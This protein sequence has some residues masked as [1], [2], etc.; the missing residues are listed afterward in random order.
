LGTVNDII[1]VV[2]LN[3]KELKLNLEKNNINEIL[4][5]C[6]DIIAHKLQEK[7]LYLKIYKNKHV[8][9][10]FMI[11]HNKFKQLLLCLLS[12]SVQNTNIGG[13]IIKLKL[14]DGIKIK[15]KH[16]KNNMDETK[17][18]IEIHRSSYLFANK[19][20]NEVLQIDNS[21]ND[22][23]SQNIQKFNSLDD[24]T[25][26]N[27]LFSIKDSGS[28]MIDKIQQYVEHILDITN[29]NTN[30]KTYSYE[31]VGLGLIISKFLCN[32]M[33]GRIWFQTMPN[34]GTIFYFNIVCPKIS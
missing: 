3:K 6:R 4:L 14:L 15:K 16:D 20:K 17:T 22:T 27:L 31:Y 7:K 25:K 23:I 29:S 26:Y 18:Y 28:G 11:D 33:G 5:D 34:I 10:E 32:L 30:Q 1:D 9:N 19:T 12:N 13:I 21:F 8:P 24:L 2:N